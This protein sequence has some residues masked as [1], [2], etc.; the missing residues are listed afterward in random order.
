MIQLV[1]PTPFTRFAAAFVLLVFAIDLLVS[2]RSRLRPMSR[3]V[4]F[5]K[6]PST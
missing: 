5:G 4:R 3:A 2:R 6:S 1:Y